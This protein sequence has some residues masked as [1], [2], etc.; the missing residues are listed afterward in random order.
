MVKES[1][2]HEHIRVF[3]DVLPTDTF[4]K[5]WLFMNLI[6]DQST[7]AGI[8]AKVWNIGDGNIFRARDHTTDQL[9]MPRCRC[10][11]RPGDRARS[12]PPRHG[13]LIGAHSHYLRVAAC[14][15]HFLP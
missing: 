10:S 4:E 9:G 5:L 7:A 6:A 14:D 13:R 3:D 15:G 1:F 11:R 2:S 12:P 8:W